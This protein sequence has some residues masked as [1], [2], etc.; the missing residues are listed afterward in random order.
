[1]NTAAKRTLCDLIAQFTS[2]RDTSLTLANK[3]EGLLIEEFPDTDI[4][5]QL[6]EALA[7]YRPGASAPYVGEEELTTYLREVEKDICGES[8]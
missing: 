5:E 7:L 4:Y 6:T 8:S 3:I 2:G 1:M